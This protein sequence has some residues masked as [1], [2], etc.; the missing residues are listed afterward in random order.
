MATTIAIS[1]IALVVP[2]IT[3]IELRFPAC[4]DAKN[5]GGHVFPFYM[6]ITSGW[7]TVTLLT[8]GEKGHLVCACI[9]R[10]IF[11]VQ[12]SHSAKTYS[13]KTTGNEHDSAA[14]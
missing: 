10:D 9:L 1:F 4:V 2:R 8:P 13:I 14:F 12:L 7:G 11:T 5:S 3:V 6:W